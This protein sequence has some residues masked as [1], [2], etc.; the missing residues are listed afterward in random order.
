MSGYAVATC[1]PPPCPL[2]IVLGAA[3][4][5]RLPPP[6]APPAVSA[7]C[8]ALTAY[9]CAAR[10]R[11][12]SFGAA[13]ASA[14]EVVFNTGMSSY[15]ESITDPSYRGQ[16]LSMTYPMIGNY[17]TTPSR[18]RFSLPEFGEKHEKNLPRAPHHRIARGRLTRLLQTVIISIL[19]APDHTA[20]DH[21][22]LM[23]Y[24]ESDQIH[25][26]GLVV[27]NYSTHYS[28]FEATQSLS[29]WMEKQGIPGICGIDTRALTKKIREHGSILGKIVPTASPDLIGFED[30]N[31]RNLIAEVSRESRR[32]MPLF[33]LFF[34]RRCFFLFFVCFCCFFLGSA[35]GGTCW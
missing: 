25:V 1:G 19:G 10:T 20:R 21:F 2:A 30:P 33:F 29:E 6:R 35:V 11:S 24:V 7:P 27:S 14:G 9:H 23:K 16:I 32:A 17:G 3:S 22:N 15:P 12:Y 13:K 5:S 31:T 18:P 34:C 4:S 8:L 28:H 26:A